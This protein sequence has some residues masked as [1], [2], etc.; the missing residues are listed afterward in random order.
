MVEFRRDRQGQPV[1]MEVN[2]RMG[3][4]LALAI[5]AVT[6]GAANEVPSHRAQP[7]KFSISDSGSP[8]IGPSQ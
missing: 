2:P 6:F 1:L 5:A 4:S 3:G 7:R 8:S